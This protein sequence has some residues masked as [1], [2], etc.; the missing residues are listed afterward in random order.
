MKNETPTVSHFQI[1]DVALRNVITIHFLLPSSQGQAKRFDLEATAKIVRLND[2][3]I[4]PDGKS[5]VVVVAHANYEENRWE[6]D[7]TLVDVATSA[8]RVF[9]SGTV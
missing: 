8:Q 2:P 1:C 9:T 3:Q 4:A 7:L 6:N 5:I